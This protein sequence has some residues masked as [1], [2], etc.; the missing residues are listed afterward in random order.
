MARVR[1]LS[2]KFF[3]DILEMLNGIKNLL[4]V[5]SKLEQTFKHGILV[6]KNCDRLINSNQRSILLLCLSLYYIGMP[7]KRLQKCWIENPSL[8]TCVK[9]LPM[10]SYWIVL[11][12]VLAVWIFQSNIFGIIGFS[13]SRIDLVEE[14]EMISKRCR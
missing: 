11:T 2:L 9:T 7:I 3:I 1:Y 4:N 14:N 6:T 10:V 8:L 13:Q 5:W 12:L